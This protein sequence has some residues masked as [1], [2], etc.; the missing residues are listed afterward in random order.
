MTTNYWPEKYRPTTLADIVLS[1]DDRAY[2]TSLKAT[3]D[4][5]NNLLFTGP[6]GTGKTTSSR[7]IV[8]DILG[9]QYLYINA[10]DENGID[11][12]RNKV[13]TFSQTQS[14]DGCL[15][16]VV[17]DECL[18]ENTLVT[19]LRNGEELQIA[20][21]DV[22][23]ISDLVKSY[24]FV[25]ERCE[26]RPFE[27]FDK[28]VQDVYEIELDNGEIVI[29]TDSHKWYV[30]NSSGEIIRKKLVDIISENI[31]EIVS[32]NDLK[33]NRLLTDEYTH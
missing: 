29:C 23:S 2:F 28:G 9:C 33:I 11:T 31:T 5:P 17:L 7:I 8:N 24:N 15:K 25:S 26:W 21:K 22:Y 18:E 4:V 13:V 6:A 3:K 16:I 14:L 19:I 1:E 12:I 20:I 10:S 27:K 30:Y 32:V